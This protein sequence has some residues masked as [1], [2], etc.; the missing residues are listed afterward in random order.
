MYSKR[1]N[2]REYRIWKAMR[3]RCSAPCLRHY[4]YQQKGIK[5]CKEWDSFNQFMIDMGEA[6][7]GYSIDRIDN[8]GNYCKEN[9]RWANQ[10]TQSR[11]R[12][13]FNLIYT[14]EGESKTL[15]EWAEVYNIKYTSLYARYRRMP[16]ATIEELV[17]FVDPRSLKIEWK[18][19]Y[20]TRQELC[21]MF[22]LPL[23]TFYDRW[24]KKWDLERILT[25]PVN[26]K[27]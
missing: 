17:T 16:G 10:T 23:Q 11:N 27:I 1:T 22:N 5:V 7:E 14:I 19:K 13:E 26:R 12:G 20:Y 18:G 9:C 15:K 25:T 2:P 8:D 21:D 6:P 24:H 3:A 4:S